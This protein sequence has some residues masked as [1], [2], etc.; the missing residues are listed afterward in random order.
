MA[1]ITFSTSSYP[2]AE[3]LEASQDVYAAMAN[4]DVALP[5]GKAPNIETRIRLLPGISIALI[6]SS[7]LI[8]NRRSRQIQDGND[9]FALLLN[10][11]GAAA[12]R[13]SLDGAPEAELIKISITSN[14]GVILAVGQNVFSN[15]EVT[16]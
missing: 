8:V 4:I 13:S 2:E 12:W 6:K 11:A 14:W 3:R 1:Y 16:T 5:R 7:P 10:P 15:Q 9:D